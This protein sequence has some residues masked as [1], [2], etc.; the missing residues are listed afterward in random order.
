MKGPIRIVAQGDRCIGR[1]SV[2]KIVDRA[3]AGGLRVALNLPSGRPEWARFH[4]LRRSA[5]P[6]ALHRDG[7]RRTPHRSDTKVSA[8]P[9]LT[10]F[11]LSRMVRRPRNAWANAT[12]YAH[13]MVEEIEGTH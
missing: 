3:P 12:E 2:A 1:H 4:R 10:V 5:R 6:A 11:S 8:F 13:V 9:R 7:P